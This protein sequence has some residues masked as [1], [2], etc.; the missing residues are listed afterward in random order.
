M[1]RAS[2]SFYLVLLN[3]IPF[4]IGYFGGLLR[5]RDAVFRGAFQNS[6]GVNDSYDFIV[7]GGGSAG[8]VIAA[9]LSENPKHRVLLLDA[10]GDPNPFS[11]IPLTVPFLQ[12]HPATDWQYKTVPS[13]TSGFAFSEQAS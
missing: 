12:N 10:G 1:I 7:V 4:L 13:N 11:Y 6:A 5:W 8:S 3:V 2:S 9:R